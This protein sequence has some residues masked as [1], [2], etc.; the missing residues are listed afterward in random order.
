MF[1]FGRNADVPAVPATGAERR[2]AYETWDAIGQCLRLL[3]VPKTE[4]VPDRLVRILEAL[5]RTNTKYENG[6]LAM[7]DASKTSRADR[8]Q[9]H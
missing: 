6:G 2:P 9:R 3:Y 1:P 8:I 5:D 7:P 4:P